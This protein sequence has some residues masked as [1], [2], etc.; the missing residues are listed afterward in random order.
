MIGSSVDKY[1]DGKKISSYP[2]HCPEFK[3]NEDSLLIGT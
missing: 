3:I 1:I 2:H